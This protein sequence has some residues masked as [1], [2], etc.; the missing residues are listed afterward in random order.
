MMQL[1]RAQK[2]L[3]SRTP[4]VAPIV[5]DFVG[6]VSTQSNLVDRAPMRSSIQWLMEQEKDARFDELDGGE[7]EDESGLPATSTTAPSGNDEI[8]KNS[9]SSSS[10][11]RG[12]IAL[13]RARNLRV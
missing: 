2:P 10:G 4:R 5:S 11:R 7:G 3:Q 1:P 6:D 13:E 12:E 8:P 9:A